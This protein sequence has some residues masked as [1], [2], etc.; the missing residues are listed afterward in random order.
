VSVA[1]SGC[2]DIGLRRPEAISIVLDFVSQ[3]ASARRRR[4]L[5][6]LSIE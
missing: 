6:R 1:R 3:V 2:G 5:Q 4:S